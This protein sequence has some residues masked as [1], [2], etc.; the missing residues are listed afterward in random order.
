MSKMFKFCALAL[1]LGCLT[2]CTAYV[3]TPRPVVYE[4]SY[5]PNVIVVSG[6]DHYHPYYHHR[7]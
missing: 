2:G 4:E 6:Y 7:Y 5:A 3:A 1:L